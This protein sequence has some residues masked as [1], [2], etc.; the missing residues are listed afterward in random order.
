LQIAPSEL[1]SGACIEI[2]LPA[3]IRIR[4][5]CGVCQDT[6][7]NVLGVLERRPC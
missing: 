6:L 4:V 3:G 2:V 1:A 7:R 5:P